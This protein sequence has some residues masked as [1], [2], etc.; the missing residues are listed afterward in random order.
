MLAGGGGGGV[1]AGSEEPAPEASPPCPPGYLSRP[2]ED[3]AMKARP[4]WPPLLCPTQDTSSS[5][6]VGVTH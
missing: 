2:E 5:L 1:E 6:T 4:A 3:N